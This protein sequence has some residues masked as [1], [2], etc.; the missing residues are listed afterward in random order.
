MV[1]RN[2]S[3]KILRHEIQEK[4]K[5]ENYF[6]CSKNIISNFSNKSCDGMREYLFISTK[7]S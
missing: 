3:K 1:S 5:E 7:Y 6:K 2:K 4:E